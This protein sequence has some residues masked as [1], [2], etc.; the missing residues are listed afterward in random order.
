MSTRKHLEFVY[1]IFFLFFMSK[2][3]QCDP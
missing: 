3:I 2:E 1:E